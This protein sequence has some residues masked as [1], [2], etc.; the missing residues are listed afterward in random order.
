MS[1]VPQDQE[2]VGSCCHPRRIFFRPAFFQLDHIIDG[3]APGIRHHNL[4]ISSTCLDNC[5]KPSF[6]LHHTHL[7]H[8][9]FTSTVHGWIKTQTAPIKPP[10]CNASSWPKVLP[11]QVTKCSANTSYGHPVLAGL[12]HT[13]STSH[14]WS[15]R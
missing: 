5:D 11:T 10:R 12:C 8:H 4:G 13:T 2:H 6:P 1:S 7:G 9:D 14:G 3:E 15:K